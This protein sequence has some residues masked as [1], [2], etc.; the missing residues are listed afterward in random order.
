MHKGFYYLTAVSLFDSKYVDG[1]GVERPT[2][3]APFKAENKHT[4]DALSIIR[5]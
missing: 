4:F 3:Y 5:Q 1:M 2:L